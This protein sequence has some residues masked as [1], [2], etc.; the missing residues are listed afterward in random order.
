M[1]IGDYILP[2]YV[3]CLIFFNKKGVGF[4]SPTPKIIE[5]FFAARDYFIRFSKLIEEGKEGI[6][7]IRKKS[8]C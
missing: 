8:M 2:E 3:T 4:Y 6:M 1:W 5:P 7:E